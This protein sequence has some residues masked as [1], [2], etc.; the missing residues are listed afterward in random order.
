MAHMIA[1][2]KVHAGGGE[3]LRAQSTDFCS[4]KEENFTPLHL[5]FHDSRVRKAPALQG[6][7]K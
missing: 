6:F 4:D 7:S 1:G 3:G 5:G 2:I